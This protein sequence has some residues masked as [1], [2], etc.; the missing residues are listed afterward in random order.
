MNPAT[1]LQN[2]DRIITGYG[3]KRSVPINLGQ[4]RKYDDG[5]I[6]N[7]T[8]TETGIDMLDTG[9]KG[10]VIFSD[11]DETSLFEFNFVVPQDYD[12]TIDKLRIRLLTSTD[13]VGT[14]TIYLG[15]ELYRKRAGAILSVDLAPTASTVAVPATVATAAWVEVDCDG[16]GLQGGDCLTIVITA[17]ATHTTDG[18]LI[19][20]IETVYAADLVYFDEGDRPL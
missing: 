2:C 16:K 15:A 9:P 14:D 18:I 17:T 4:C 6:L 3:F 12:K 11:V 7:A 20:G 19:Y 1:F 10:F 8:I 13:A 5:V